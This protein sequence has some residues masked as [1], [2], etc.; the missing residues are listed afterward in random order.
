MDNK[1]VNI[2]ING[3]EYTVDGS[4]TILEACRKAGIEIPT[5]CYMKDV[6]EEGSCGICVVDVAKARTLQRACI[7]QVFDGMDIKTN[8]PR[9]RKARKTIIELILANHPKDCLNCSAS[10]I[11]E[12]RKIAYDLGV[13]ETPFEQTKDI[14]LPLDLT[15]PAIVRDLNKCIL[16]RR[17]VKV[18]EKRISHYPHPS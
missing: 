3:V 2:K 11:C 12:L 7:T 15:S 14:D 4:S 10:E 5:L 16:C 6:C 8:T 18:C 1:T 9:V 13:T 17:C